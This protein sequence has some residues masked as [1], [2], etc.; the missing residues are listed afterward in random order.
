MECCRLVL[1]SGQDSHLLHAGDANGMTPVS[2]AVVNGHQEYVTYDIYLS[3]CF[4][5]LSI[6]FVVC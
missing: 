3:I 1:E 4:G 2:A 5:F 6:L